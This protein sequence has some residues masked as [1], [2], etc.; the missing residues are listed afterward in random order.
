VLNFLKSVLPRGQQPTS[1]VY[2]SVFSDFGGSLDDAT[3]YNCR[4]HRCCICSGFS[5]AALT[6]STLGA[7]Y[8]P[9]QLGKDQLGPSRRELHVG[10]YA[11]MALATVPLAF[12]NL[13]SARRTARGFLQAG[14]WPSTS[15]FRDLAM[16]APCRVGS[17]SD[18]L[19]ARRRGTGCFRSLGAGKRLP[20]TVDRLRET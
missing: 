11:L 17:G 3:G 16:R 4:I 15:R 14:I 19:V 6:D 18:R 5:V 8:G 20:Q 9:H 2:A 12:P 13:M 10:P 1:V 7:A